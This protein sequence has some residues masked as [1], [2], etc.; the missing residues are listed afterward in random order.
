[1]AVAG[2]ACFLLVS[3]P[4]LAWESEDVPRLDLAAAQQALLTE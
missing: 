4:P 3:L 1:V 2:L